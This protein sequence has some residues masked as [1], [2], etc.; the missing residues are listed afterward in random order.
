MAVVGIAPTAGSVAQVGHASPFA[1]PAARTE[2]AGP[3]SVAMSVASVWTVGSARQASASH[4][5]HSA[6][7]RTAVTMGAMIVAGSA[8]QVGRAAVV[9]AN[10]RACRNAATRRAEPMVAAACAG[11]VPA[12]RSATV[13]ACACWMAAA[14]LIASA[15]RMVVATRA[16][17]AARGRLATLPPTDVPPRHAAPTPAHS[18]ATKTQ[19]AS[20]RPLRS[21][22]AKRVAALG[23]Q[24]L[25]TSHGSFLP[26]G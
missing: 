19:R 24:M 12:A 1:S 5:R 10:L 25:V 14:A 16:D 7:E 18:G 22:A 17:H 6:Q 23:R 2:T 15:A 26:A 4:A 21:G 9:P 8:R 11:H 13:S 3:T 20:T